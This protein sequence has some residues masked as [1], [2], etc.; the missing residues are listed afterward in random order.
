MNLKPISLLIAPL[1]MLAPAG[2]C[3]KAYGAAPALAA[4]ETMKAPLALRYDK[5]ADQDNS[6]ADSKDD[7]HSGTHRLRRVLFCCIGNHA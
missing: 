2:L 3:S 4:S 7:R 6:S 1:A 5:P